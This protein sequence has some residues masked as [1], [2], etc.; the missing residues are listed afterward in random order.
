MILSF[1]VC[2]E[3]RRFYH[4]HPAV[5]SGYDECRYAGLPLDQCQSVLDAEHA[6]GG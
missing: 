2:P 5:V 6:N 4:L 1:W 3:A